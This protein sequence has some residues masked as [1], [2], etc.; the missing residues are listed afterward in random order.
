MGHLAA[1]QRGKN[2]LDQCPRGI[3]GQLDRDAI[4]PALALIGEVD[5]EHVIER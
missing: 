4:T 3:C 5:G 2:P 1:R